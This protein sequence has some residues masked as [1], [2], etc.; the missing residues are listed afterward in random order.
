M[1]KTGFCELP[2][3]MTLSE[4]HLSEKKFPDEHFTDM[5]SVGI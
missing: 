5:G 2:T 3:K 4:N 1:G